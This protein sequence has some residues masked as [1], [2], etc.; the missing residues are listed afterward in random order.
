MYGVLYAVTPEL[1]P[2]KDRGTGNALTATG[3]RICGVMVRENSL[4]LFHARSYG[5]VI[6]MGPHVQAPVIALYAN[7]NT[8]VPIF[9]AG[10]VFITAGFIALL[11]PYETRGRGSL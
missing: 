1:F 4:F 9:I 8:P 6:E 10:A 7:L 11:L 2:T 5:V 3:N